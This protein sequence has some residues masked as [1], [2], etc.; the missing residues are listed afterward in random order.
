[1]YNKFILENKYKMVL[2]IQIIEIALVISMMFISIHVTNRF[3]YN[4][5]HPF[6]YYKGMFYFLVSTSVMVTVLA[7]K[8]YFNFFDTSFLKSVSKAAGVVIFI[9]V[10][11]I[12]FLYFSQ[13]SLVTAY[14]FVIIAGLQMISLLSIKV[15]TNKFKENIFRRQL[16]VI[17]GNDR[18]KN[19]LIE[20]LK[21][22]SLN[23]VT[24]V[25]ENDPN[26]YDHIKRADY[27]YLLIVSTKELKDDIIAYCELHDIRIF[28]VPESHEIALRDA[29]LTQIGDVPLFAV[30]RYRLTEGQV[31]VKRIIDIV[32]ALAAIFLVAPIILI[33]GIL[34]KK[35]DGGPVFYL[36]ERCGLN[37][38]PFKMIKMRSMIVDAEKYTGEVL[39]QEN[40]PRITKIGRIIRATRIDEIPQFFNVL[41]GSMSV[42]GPRPER[43]AFVEEY[44]SQY[45]EYIHR[46]AVKPGITG[47][48]QVM[49]NYTTTSE[50][51]LKFDLIYIKKYS[52]GYDFGILIKTIG[53][54]FSKEQSQGVSNVDEGKGISEVGLPHI[55]SISGLRLKNKNFKP[56][57][58]RKVAVILVSC[59]IVIISSMFLRYTSLAVAAVEAVSVD[60]ATTVTPQEGIVEIEDYEIP[61][62][63]LED[64]TVLSQMDIEMKLSTLGSQ[65]KIKSVIL[66]L[67]NLS[68][69]ELMLIEELQ[70][71]GL[72]KSEILLIHDIMDKNFSQDEIDEL[73]ELSLN[74]N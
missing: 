14:Y 6:G 5:L 53:V 30:E 63:S 28:M 60:I 47:L 37:K 25:S 27:V 69:K 15:V 29:E 16:S 64:V 66:L 43:P 41:L 59:F 72:S 17:V 35:E 54:V 39:A 9:N 10:V 33:V 49:S 8:D 56:Y 61:L 68:K 70:E 7:A 13:S 65:H 52:P 67:T 19:I 20:A 44:L 22:Q 31:I 42:V 62:A 1:M 23:R 38:K 36:Q 4:E 55:E 40:D 3:V 74:K 51:K 24:F 34:I 2:L 46:F 12:V 32:L 45:P 73:K 26:L 48:A 58:F 57:S 21:K 50:N 11:M 18:E 71:N